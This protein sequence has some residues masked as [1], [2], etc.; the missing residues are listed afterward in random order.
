MPWKMV[1]N[2]T[3][4]LVA[5]VALAAA[6]ALGFEFYAPVLGEIAVGD[7]Q[8]AKPQ[9]PRDRA[10]IKVERIMAADPVRGV[11]TLADIVRFHGLEQDTLECT[12][13]ENHQGAAGPSAIPV[14]A[15]RPLRAGDEV[16]LCLD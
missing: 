6:A 3:L 11:P 5:L 1:G 10:V 9:V 4:V 7:E 14:L 2:G 12:V 8:E 13:Q 16:T 15:R